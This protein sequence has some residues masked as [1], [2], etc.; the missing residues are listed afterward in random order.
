MADSWV[1]LGSEVNF[2]QVTTLV[3]VSSDVVQ[4]LSD[5]LGVVATALKVVSRL[6]VD[7]VNAIK[8]TLDSAVKTLQT[9]ILDLL[10]N[11]V[12]FTVHTNVHWNPEWEFKDFDKSGA[13]PWQ[14]TG[15][16]G[17]LME[18]ASSAK[19]PSDPF[20]PITDDS[21]SVS[22]VIFLNGVTESGDI[23][24]LKSIYKTFADFSD[25]SNLL[26]TDI[27]G[28]ATEG[29]KAVSR[30]GPTMMSPFSRDS[31]GTTAEE[32]LAG[33]QQST[34]LAPQDTFDFTVFIP[35]RGAYPKWISIPLAS[36]IP[37][38]GDI[39]AVLKQITD[40]LKTAPSSAEVVSRLADL[41]RRKTEVLTD[42]VQRIEVILETIIDVL[43]FFTGAYIL[44]LPAQT[45]GFDTF[46]KRAISATLYDDGSSPPGPAFGT[47]G[48]VA[49]AVAIA[50]AS[51]PQNALDSFLQF[52]GLQIDTLTSDVTV[53]AQNL[54]DQYDDLFP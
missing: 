26:E 7:G 49:G 22:G 17:W 13:L 54:K 39:F 30:L 11:N 6:I 51:D 33:I 20:R 3:G 29:L 41:L 10:E 47:R 31:L 35:T 19:D 24:S 4:T 32:I 38:L 27:F 43:D 52:C 23:S 28:S 25:F 14:G 15:L 5:F 37:S 2:D 34:G 16:E 21:T 36:L 45:G 44:L 42:A 9:A 1:R 53:R 18:V 8:S 50:T 48:I 46:I 40:G 12:A